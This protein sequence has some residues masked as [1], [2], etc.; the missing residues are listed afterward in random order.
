MDKTMADK[1]MYIPTPMMIHKTTSSVDYNETLVETFGHST[2][3]INQPNS[4]KVLPEMENIIGSVF[5]EI[6]GY[7]IQ[8][9]KIIVW[10]NQQM[11]LYNLK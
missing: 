8:I 2:K 4:I 11:S 9:K 7:G 3:L 5:I 10:D 6:L 1:L